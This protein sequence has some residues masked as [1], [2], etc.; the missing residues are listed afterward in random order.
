M[1][2]TPKG[3]RV[4]GLL[5]LVAGV[6]GAI[7]AV[8]QIAPPGSI[9]SSVPKV[10]GGL[11]EFKEA[12]GEVVQLT[13]WTPPSTEPANVQSVQIR[14]EQLAWNAHSGENVANGGVDT[15]RGSIYESLG[16]NLHLQRETKDDYSQMQALLVACANELASGADNCT[17]GVQF[18]TIMGDG[19]PAFF[20]GLNATLAKFGPDYVAE[21]VGGFGRSYG[22][23][24][25]MGPP[26]CAKDANA[27]RGLLVAG[28]PRDGDWNIA[29]LFARDNGI[30]NNPDKSTWDPDC[31]NWVETASFIEA[32]EK[33]IQR[34]CEERPVVRNGRKTGETKKVCVDAVVTWT[35]GDVAVTEGRGGIVRIRSTRENDSQMPNTVIGIRKWNQTHHDLVVKFLA[36]GL[37]GGDLVRSNPDALLEAG[38]V[39]AAVYGEHD[40]AWWARMYRGTEI[41]DKTGRLSVKVGGSRAFNAS[42][43]ERYWGMAS[44]YANAFDATYT[45]FGNI[46]KQQYPG[47]MDAFPSASE[48]FDSRYLREAIAMVRE[49]GKEVAVVD[50]PVFAASESATPVVKL[51]DRNVTIEFDTGRDSIKSTSAKVLQEML[52]GMTVTGNSKIELHGYTDDIGEDDVN[53]AL[54]QARASSV[55]KWLQEHAPGNFPEERFAKVEGH[56]EQDPLVPNVNG[57]NRAKNRRVRIVILANE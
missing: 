12:E 18:V 48:V 50:E 35:P 56:G 52:D 37:M 23:D 46:A 29:L 9:A 54:S 31:L 1:G 16:V 8:K 13:N 5:F 51:G 45:L 38:R 43:A 6:G 17:R 3:R 14:H 28:V 26:E 55:K 53:L 57:V 22:E 20:A 27:C 36:G 4:A 33:F 30:C 10:D 49:R 21:T 24:A 25:F 41:S 11:A 39:N 40:A 44:G 42:D 47:L 7:L 32:D 34:A 15:T 19:G 2:M